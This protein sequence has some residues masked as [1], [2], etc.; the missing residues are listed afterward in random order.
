MALQSVVA[1]EH[2]IAGYATR[3]HDVGVLVG[4]PCFAEIRWDISGSVWRRGVIVSLVHWKLMGRGNA[5][6]CNQR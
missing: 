3:A 2:S 4:T 1:A 5:M 6:L